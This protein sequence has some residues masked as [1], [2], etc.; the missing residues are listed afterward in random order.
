MTSAGPGQ[1]AEGESQDPPAA[2]L[3]GRVAAAAVW[4]I[5]M[6][7][8]E[9]VLGIVSTLILARLLVPAD[10]GL[11][12]MATVV[13]AFM[14]TLTASGV[15]T[16]MISKTRVDRADYDTAWTINVLLGAGLF[17][18]IVGLAWPAAAYFRTPELAPVLGVLS[19]LPLLYGFE[20]IGTIDFRRNLEFDRD[21]RFVLGKKLI[22]LV[23][24]VPLAL[25]WRN[26]WALVA[27]LLSMRLGGV[28]LSF[29]MSPYRP[30]FSL[31]RFHE[32]FHFSKWL[33]LY[34]FLVFLRLR[35]TDFLTGRLHGPGAL[36]VFT[37]ANELASM[38]TTE[39]VMPVNRALFPGYS[40]MAEDL[41]RLGGAFVRAVGLVTL[42]AIPAS[43]G[44]V[45]VADDAVP[46]L[47]GAKWMATVPVIQLLAIAGVST[48]LQISCWSVF[49]ATQRFKFLVYLNLFHLAVMIPAMFFFVPPQGAVGAALAHLTACVASLPVGFAMVHAVTGAPI[50]AQAGA[51]WR[52][53]LAAV[54]MYAVVEAVKPGAL[55]VDSPPL[56]LLLGLAETIT[57]GAVVYGAGI[58]LLWLAS[59][60]PRSAEWEALEYLRG[61]LRWFRRPA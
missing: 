11:V 46:L 1:S 23:T 41:Q 34:N 9:R 58:A 7:V 33:A 39:L 31:Q 26:H 35:L 12:A 53:A 56:A 3:S 21:V 61:R 48:A 2:S 59:G 55:G 57:V 10:Y 6:R 32:F 54:A 17:A 25:L 42:L 8:G 27:G 15:D 14:E 4:A 24:T 5:G 36:G 40:K 44:L 29:T 28:V 20:N 51:V 18:V 52:P 49:M 22:S 47:L 30:R 16:V 60:R 45:L 38:P 50:A 19:L 13:I 43:V 37:M